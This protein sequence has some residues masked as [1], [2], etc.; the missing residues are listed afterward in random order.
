MIT[1]WLTAY[2]IAVVAQDAEAGPAPW[3]LR[4]IEACLGRFH[5]TSK[6]VA[7]YLKY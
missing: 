7:T 3:R 5:A 4:A 2:E 6:Y 1:D